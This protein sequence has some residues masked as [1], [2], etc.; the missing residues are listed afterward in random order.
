[1]SDTSTLELREGDIDEFFAVPFSIYPATSPYVSPMQSDLRRFLDVARNPL[2][3]RRGRGTF[4]TARRG[5]KPIGRIVAHVHD[6]SNTLH[7]TNRSCFGYFDCANDDEAA[8]T[9]LG[10]A[11]RWGR[12]HG[13]SEIAG[14]FNLTAM[15]QMGVL[16]D[17]FDR[18][19]FTDMQYNPPH[20]ATLLEANGYA[21]FFPMTTFELDLTMFDPAKCVGPAEMDLLSSND[22]QWT[23][24][25]RR[26]FRRQLGDARRILNES[27]ARNPMF[28]PLSDEEFLFQAQEM[29]W[30][31][32]DRIALL[33]H[34]G[35]EPAGVIVCIPDLNQF[36]RDT[37]SRVAL[38]TPYHYVRHLMHRRR[39]L[40]VFAGVRPEFQKRG[41]SGAMLF[42][43]T[44]A[45]Q[46]AGYT[47]LG[48]TWVSD[49]NPAPLRQMEK[50]GARPMHRL[51]LYRKSLAA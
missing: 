34:H 29:M 26:T 38:S 44:T 10:A 33:A 51:H 14:N 30:I 12:E 28:V 15:Q 5:G 36:I 46:R 16:T 31:V 1:M 2:F 48:I 39:A 20:I 27:F 13:F 41:L 43:I 4:F 49:D 21:R 18:A 47:S 23:P 9:L 7:A 3:Q 25:R 42:R 6:A 19:P 17:G 50:L 11:E 37:K 35:G 32:D 8:R 45:M 24:L 40:L 22:V